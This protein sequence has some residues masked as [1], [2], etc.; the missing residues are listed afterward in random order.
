M[1]WLVDDILEGV[2][3]DSIFSDGPFYVDWNKVNLKKGKYRDLDQF[4]ENTYQAKAGKDYSVRKPEGSVYFN[5]KIDR[6]R[7]RGIIHGVTM[8]IG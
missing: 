8:G 1:S 2:I 3:E 5:S 7:R 4:I 6:S